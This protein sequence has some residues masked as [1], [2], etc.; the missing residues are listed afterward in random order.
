MPTLDNLGSHA[1]GSLI[2]E[3]QAQKE[4]T[5]NALDN[6]VS[7]ATQK[8]LAITITDA[9]GSP[10]VANRTLTDD[11]F[12]GNLFFRLSGSPTVAIEVLVPAAGN[13]L[14]VVENTTG[15]VATLGTDSGGSP[16]GTTVQVLDGATRILHSDG[17]DLREIGSGAPYDIGMFVPT[18][19]EGA[20]AAQILVLR[21]FTLRA[22]APGS[23]A[24]AF[25]VTS[26]GEDPVVFDVRRNNVSF[27]T[28]TFDPP[29]D[30]GVFTQA[31]DRSFGVGDLLQI[32]NPVFG[33]PAPE[34]TLANVSVTFKIDL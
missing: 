34:T 11:E 3:S 4:I 8:P 14:F 30:T 31:S 26:S 22:G 23:Q 20:L 18:V 12:F 28:V 29:T 15:R 2:A 10:A 24:K 25:A 5:S 17:T 13:H 6:L 1:D 27:G 19:T 9:A 7:N 21:P 16:G 32:V 33:S